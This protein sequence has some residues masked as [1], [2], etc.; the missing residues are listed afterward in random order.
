MLREREKEI[1]GG[2]NLVIKKFLILK[3]KKKLKKFEVVANINEKV[4]NTFSDF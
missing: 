4:G 2:Y 1:E 3:N